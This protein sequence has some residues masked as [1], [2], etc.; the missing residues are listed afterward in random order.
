MSNPFENKRILLGVT[1]S[2]ACYKACDLASR[3]KQAGTFVDVVLTESATR[4]ITPLSFESVTGR[5]AYTDKDLWGGEG[6]VL[7]VSL[8]Q[9][10]DLLL[11]A[12]ATA[13]TIAKLAQGIADNLLTDS[14]LVSTCP[15]VISP[16]MESHMYANAATQHN[17]HV[18]KER[19][20]LILGPAEGHLASGAVGKGRFV[21]PANIMAELRWIMTRTGRLKG[22]K[23]VVTAGGTQE[24]IDPVRIISNYSSGK[25]G[26]ALAQSALDAGAEVILISAPNA[27][28]LPFGA[29]Q[30]KVRTAAEMQDA[31]LK[32]CDHADVLIMAAAVADFRPQ[33]IETQKIKKGSG[34]PEIKLEP[35]EDILKQVAKNKSKTGFP[36]LTVGFA[37]ESQDLIDNAREKLAS[38]SLDLIVA[39]DITRSDSGFEVDTNTIT[40]IDKK[41]R[42]QSLP[43]LT[44][45]EVADKVIDFVIH[46]LR[47]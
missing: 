13:N 44:K 27:L 21:E 8:G 22:K 36:I 2:I 18:L 1:G 6:H 46:N 42:A 20:A 12:P 9:S 40:L 26:F 30:V 14:V 17:L 19:G 4:F 3:L 11:V 34:I 35:T 47:L 37:A 39:N 31:V 16:A 15:L 33:Q 24:S 23:V 29:S 28:D 32:A 25:Q 38:K 5:K 10:A 7:H 45:T 41:G 43:T